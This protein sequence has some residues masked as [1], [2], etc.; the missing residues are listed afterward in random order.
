MKGQLA[1]VAC[2]LIIL[3]AD[4]MSYELQTHGYLS[5]ASFDQ[6]VLQNDASRARLGLIGGLKDSR[7]QFRDSSGNLWSIRQLLNIGVRNEDDAPR[8][9][10]H[11]FNPSDGQPLHNALTILGATSPNWALGESLGNSLLNTFSYKDARGHFYDALTSKNASVRDGSWGL[12]FE[13]LGHIIHHIHDMAQ[14]QHVRNDQH[15]DI[16]WINEACDPL[17][18]LDPPLSACLAY[19]TVHNKSL[20]EAWTEARIKGPGPIPTS[21]YSPVYDVA[22]IGVDGQSVFT[23]PI[24]FWVN[25]GKGIAE[26]T[27]RNFFSAGTLDVTPPNPGAP[28]D[29]NVMTLC[30][31]AVPPCADFPGPWPADEMVTF[32]PSLVDD[33]F[34]ASGP[35]VQPYAQGVSIFDPEFLTVTNQRLPTVNRFTF[36]TDH[37]FLLP[38]AVGY[39]AGLINYFFRGD[40][41][42]GLPPE[43]TY[44]VVDTSAA[45]CKSP[46][47][48]RKVSMFVR[49]ITPHDDM[50]AGTLVAVVKYHLNTCFRDDYSGDDG[51]PNFNGLPCRSALEY[52]AVST[53]IAV[54]TV[55]RA[56]AANP[57][58]FTFPD[59]APIPINASDVYLQI[60]FRGILGAETDG[61]AVT[62]KKISEPNYFAVGNITDYAFDDLGDQRYHPIPYKLT[63]NPIVLDTVS[64]WLGDPVSSNA[65][66]ATLTALGAKQHAQIA[67]MTDTGTFHFWLH[68]GSI[69]GYPPEDNVELP[70]DAFVLEDDVNPPV[71]GR[72]CPLTPARG[73]YRQIFRDY[74][75]I[76]HSV[77][78]FANMASQSVVKGAVVAS[79]GGFRETLGNSRNGTA[80]AL[81]AQASDCFPSPPPGSGGLYDQSY[82]V[83]TFTPQNA[84]QW[85]LKAGW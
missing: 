10:N 72:T 26:Y 84:S 40:L 3:S 65:P 25:Q 53:P 64:L 4:V 22:G 52:V 7:L 57:T 14:P 63:F 18:L 28:Y 35:I 73:M 5:D 81:T 13:S 11:F 48:F 45:G 78:G 70:V 82:L 32:L 67:F 83:P 9:I 79:A 15:L 51:G 1:P 24:T 60:V 50:G 58:V 19:E 17:P 36:A 76:A 2:F 37:E 44:A 23:S 29:I 39:S 49:N 30:T 59:P 55:D 47:G 54:A 41:E 80:S 8:P 75:Q 42:I 38:R 56:F 68:T 71:F 34:R 62:T 21:G 74:A 33:K 20:Y 46:C 27:N 69:A 31:G 61:I 85:Q 6:S 16:D 66:L 43:G 12:T 77:V